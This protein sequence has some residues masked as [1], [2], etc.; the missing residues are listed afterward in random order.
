MYRSSLNLFVAIVLLATGSCSDKPE[1]TSTNLT[2]AVYP[3][4]AIDQANISV[5]NTSLQLYTLEVFDGKG[6]LMMAE[7]VL[8][9][10]HQFS[11]DLRT[12][13][14]GYYHVSLVTEGDVLTQKLLKP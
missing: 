8:P 7:D 3:N 1:D 10:Q 11:V 9:G 12:K 14:S 4:P 2:L 5:R 6:K 13:P